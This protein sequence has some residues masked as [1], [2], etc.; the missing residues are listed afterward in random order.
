MTPKKLQELL[1][2]ARA[3]LNLL[4]EIGNALR[5]TLDFNE[6]LYIILTGVTS[7]EGLGFNRAAIFLVNEKD[8][9]LEGRMGIGPQTGEE[10]QEMWEG[11]RK[12]G[13]DMQGLISSYRKNRPLDT[14]FHAMTEALKIPL[15]EE[16]GG[17]LA[18][19]ALEGMPIEIIKPE[20]E[21][22]AKKDPFL[23]KL[24]TTNCV[25]VP[26]KARDERIV[27]VI[28][29]DNRITMKPITRESFRLL[30]LLAAH[31]GLAIDN[32]LLYQSVQQQANLDP[33]TQVWNRGAFQH[34]LIE[35]K[36]STE[37]DRQTFSLL[38]ADLDHFKTYNDT[39][40]HLGGDQALI[41]VAHL[42]KSTA[43]A[44]DHV[45][46]YGGDE[47]AV[48][49]ASARTSDALVMAQRIQNGMKTTGISMTLS[50]GVATFPIDAHDSES[51]IQAADRAL[52]EAK[53]LGR[54]RVSDASG[55][56][57]AP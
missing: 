4:Y 10:A 22:R 29:A 57:T 7:H 53:R 50:I 36:T 1:E 16:A 27:G 18:L 49:L 23:S 51:L 21:E 30:A 17:M 8:K 56:N 37:R 33:L 52:Y 40:G 35:T 19:T 41:A 48:I 31:A 42:L 47:F 34:F 32:A 39:M 25:L 2:K 28:F 15:D 9:T 26:L 46:R 6:T 38:L 45:A 24:Q 14:P 3:E 54:N 5:S 11:I 44:G 13:L 55:A 43:R 12:K 20:A